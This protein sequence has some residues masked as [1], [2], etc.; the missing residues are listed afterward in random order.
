M[1]NSLRSAYDSIIDA[2]KYPMEKC[3][4]FKYKFDKKAEKIRVEMSWFG[5]LY[6]ES[7]QNLREA[8]IKVL[9]K[10]CDEL[11]AASNFKSLSSC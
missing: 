4:S 1:E 2:G 7:G 8:K 9:E 10:F 11:N 5:T 6:Q 3:L